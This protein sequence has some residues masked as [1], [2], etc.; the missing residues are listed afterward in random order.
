MKRQTLQLS[1]ITIGPLG[2]VLQ[3]PRQPL[4]TLTSEKL[5]NITFFIFTRC[6]INLPTATSPA[7]HLS[8]PYSC[9]GLYLI[10]GSFAITVFNIYRRPHP[11]SHPAH[12]HPPQQVVPPKTLRV[13]LKDTLEVINFS[14]LSPSRLSEAHQIT[15]QKYDCS[16][17]SLSVV[18]MAPL[19]RRFQ[20]K[21]SPGWLI[22]VDN[23]TFALQKQCK[24]CKK[25][26]G[27]LKGS[28]AA[29][30]STIMKLRILALKRDISLTSYKRSLFGRS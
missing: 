15:V 25:K 28:S 21:E 14:R 17:K 13:L 22:C 12:P 19:S 4:S 26:G 7:S 27:T 30:V 8:S 10:Q 11:G 1:S 9:P 18:T 24:A 2:V 20:T 29:V 16:K 23:V 6:C 5:R 3:F